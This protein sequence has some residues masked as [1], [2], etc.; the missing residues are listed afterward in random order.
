MNLDPAIHR[1]FRKTY[2]CPTPAIFLD[3]DGVIVEEVG[4]LHRSED[5]QLILPAAA[6]IAVFNHLNIP[7]VVV[8]NQAGIARGY[9]QWPDFKHCQQQIEQQLG[10]HQAHLDGVWA[11]GALDTGHEFRKP[12]PG[13]LRDAAETMNLDLARSWI[14]GDKTIDILTG[15]HARLE[16]AIL[17]R[18]GYG[19]DMEKEVRT[20]EP[21]TSIHVADTLFDAIGILGKHSR[22]I[23]MNSFPK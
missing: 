18:T 9:Y 7:V 4:Y 2:P 17:V 22:A 13:M 23:M 19:A 3:R 6:A 12:N 15:I 1:C 16:G 21:A 14:I 5:I 11:C 10:A 20:L 8:T